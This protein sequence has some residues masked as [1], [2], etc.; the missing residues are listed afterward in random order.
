MLDKIKKNYLKISVLFFV[1]FIILT[2]VASRQFKVVNPYKD[3]SIEDNSAGKYYSLIYNEGVLSS[4]TSNSTVINIL[5]K[6]LLLFSRAFYYEDI[7]NTKLCA[8]TFMPDYK[9]I[10]DNTYEFKGKYYGVSNLVTLKITNIK[11]NSV[12]LSISDDEKNN[13]DKQLSLNGPM[14]NLIENLPI[15]DKFYSVRYYQKSGEII[16]TFYDGY[17]I[18][19][20][21]TALKKITDSLGVS[22]DLYKKK[23]KYF[24]NGFGE[25]SIEDIKKNQSTYTLG[26]YWQQ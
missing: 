16:T 3:K 15:E 20:V 25:R 8:F 9:K 11:N 21:D 10:S 13:I 26:S 12:R 14:T 23:I 22:T 17:R 5:K 24:V 1:L 4:V 7:D 6:D 18:D 19:S 2:I